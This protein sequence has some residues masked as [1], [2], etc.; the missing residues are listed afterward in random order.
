[1]Q[2]LGRPHV[3]VKWAQ[4]LDGRAAASDGTSQWITGSAARLD[5]HRRRAVADAIVAGIGTV[6]A[7]DP[8]LTARDA[9][10]DLLPQQPRPVVLG[11]RPVP[12]GAAVRRHPLPLLQ[13]GGD[14]LP[15]ALADLRE[16]GVQRVFV[17]GG[18]TIA[19]AFL[20]EG[21]ADE[22]L[23]YIAP[24]LLGGDKL[25]LGDIG[26]GTIRE[27]RRLTVSS[28]ERLDDDL[29]VIAT[30]EARTAVTAG[31]PAHYAEGDE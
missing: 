3:T 30:P 14:D 5:V 10:G 12:A 11:V 15:A 29:L 31:A 26:I 9:A 21:L 19:S 24:V 27:A 18:P 23:A 4:S 22:V 2:R 7:D 28:V 16:Q 20:R 25:A 13:Y 1:V 8:A 6:L 17:E